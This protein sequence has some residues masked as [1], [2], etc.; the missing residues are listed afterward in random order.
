MRRDHLQMQ[1]SSA[2]K[3]PRFRMESICARFEYCGGYAGSAPK[4]L[5]R[6]EAYSGIRAALGGC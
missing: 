5:V 3:K 6:C 2:M 4:V 1:S